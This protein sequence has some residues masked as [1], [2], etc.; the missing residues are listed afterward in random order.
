MRIILALV[1]AF[2]LVACER[3]EQ[4][5]GI[6]D[7][8]RAKN[9]L[10]ELLLTAQ[11]AVYDGS[12]TLSSVADLTNELKRQGH[13][14]PLSSFGETNILFNKH[15]VA[16]KLSSQNA[17]SNSA[18]PAIAIKLVPRGFAVIT[19]GYAF[20]KTNQLPRSVSD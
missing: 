3:P 10:K 19:F 7:E 14:I 15:W 2:L 6:T 1:I 16:W 8:V 18:L 9:A 12:N 17:E 13:F 20:I 11:I 4:D 5:H